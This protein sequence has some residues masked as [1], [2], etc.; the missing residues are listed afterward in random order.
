MA[1]SP[2]PPLNGQGVQRISGYKFKFK[3]N[4]KTQIGIRLGTWNVG[5]LCSRGTEV[6]EEGEYLWSKKGSIEGPRS[7]TILRKKIQVMVVGK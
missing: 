3:N 7:S 4:K 2:Q 6:A 5:S 1:P